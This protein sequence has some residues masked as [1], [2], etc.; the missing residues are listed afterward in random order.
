MPLSLWVGSVRE[1]ESALLPVMI[2]GDHMRPSRLL[3]RITAR[4]GSPLWS[5]CHP[6]SILV[7]SLLRVQPICRSE[8]TATVKVHQRPGGPYRS[9]FREEKLAFVHFCA[10][11]LAIRRGYWTSSGELMPS[12]SCD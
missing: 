5:R 7:V 12:A 8:P 10:Q 9:L 11:I 3:L 1:N 4:L 6:R 2:S